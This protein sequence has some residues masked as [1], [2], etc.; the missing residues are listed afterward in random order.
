MSHSDDD[1]TGVDDESPDLTVAGLV[2]QFIQLSIGT[3]RALD[4]VAKAA[5]DQLVVMDHAL[6][7]AAEDRKAMHSL[8]SALEADARSRTEFRRELLALLERRW[9]LLLIGVG[10]GL[11]VAGAGRLVSLVIEAITSGA[12]PNVAK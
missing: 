6:S 1:E 10:I 3:A 5:K 9:V 4:D 11:G 8:S 7:N 2:K 12:I